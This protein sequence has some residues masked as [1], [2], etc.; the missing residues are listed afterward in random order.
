MFLARQEGHRVNEQGG[1][2]DQNREQAGGEMGC[3]KVH[4]GVGNGDAD[5]ATEEEIAD[6]GPAVRFQLDPVARC[7]ITG[8]RGG[9][10]QAK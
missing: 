6:R 3:A 4:G 5:E 10:S 7:A 2:V 9:E 8:R 1:G